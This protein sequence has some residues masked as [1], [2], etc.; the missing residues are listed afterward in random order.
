MSKPNVKPKL[1]LES[2]VSK[3]IYCLAY[4]LNP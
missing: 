4:K 2:K 1:D 3:P